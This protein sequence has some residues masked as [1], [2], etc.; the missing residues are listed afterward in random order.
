MRTV[1]KQAVEWLAA[2][3]ANPRDCKREWNGEMGAVVLACGRYWDV[4]SVPEDLGMLA[5]D[6]LLCIPQP[7]GPR[8][9]TPP[10]AGWP[11][12]CRRTPKAAGS[13]RAS[14]MRAEAPGSR[15]PHRIEPPGDCAG[16][17][18]PTAPV[19]CSFPPPWSCLFSWRSA[20]SLPRPPRGDGA[21]R[22]GCR[23]RDPAA[24]VAAGRA[25]RGRAPQRQ[26]D[27]AFPPA[28][29]R[30]GSRLLALPGHRGGDGG[31]GGPLRVPRTSA[32][33]E[34]HRSHLPS[35]TRFLNLS[36]HTLGLRSRMTPE[37]P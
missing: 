13:V 32:P 7:P 2:A 4:L 18:R 35:I 3:A 23:P 8:S 31:E 26:F 17:S 15:C 16:W 10:P 25:D 21:R 9:R 5:L 27:A 37:F 22:A 14:G 34:H 11:S 20:N 12:S 1:T 19:R 28:R 24:A 36:A 33:E 30:H 6:A 29:A